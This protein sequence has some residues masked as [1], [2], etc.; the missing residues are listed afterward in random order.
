MV[1]P[2]GG[3]PFFVPAAVTA[4]RAMS[5]APK[6]KST[7]WII[8][9]VA[10]ALGCP[11]CIGVSAAVAIPG[12][13]SYMQRSKTAEAERE[14]D[15]LY[16]SAAAYYAMENWGD[17]SVLSNDAPAVAQTSCTV[18]SARTS[19]VPSSAKT[20]IDWTTEADSFEQLGFVIGDPVYYQYEI[21][22]AGARCG[23]GPNTE[24]Y[25]FRAYGDLDG[26]GVQS[27]FT[28][29]ARSNAANTMER[30]EITRENELE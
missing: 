28:L 10:V 19:N 26:D 29:T 5:S 23:H 4:C 9:I 21:V 15:H 12:F 27:V 14:L 8:A 25:T 18:A 24:L 6:K 7:V 17:R 30:S 22:S 1:G 20:V 2:T 16:A 13:L 3:E 11:I